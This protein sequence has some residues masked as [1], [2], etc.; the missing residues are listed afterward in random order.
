MRLNEVQSIIGY[1]F[2]DASLLE[3]ALTHPSYSN[4]KGIE[5]YQRLEYLGDAQQ[6]A[7]QYRRA[8]VLGRGSY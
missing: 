8:H 2:K 7:H 5:D 6:D 3:A 4:G 1:V